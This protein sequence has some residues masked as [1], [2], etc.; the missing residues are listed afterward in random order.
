MTLHNTYVTT[1]DTTQHTSYYT[2]GTTIHNTTQHNTTQHTALHYTQQQHYYTRHCAYL[3]SHVPLSISIKVC[4]SG[5]WFVWGLSPIRTPCSPPWWSILP[6]MGGRRRVAFHARVVCSHPAGHDATSSE[7]RRREREAAAAGRPRP[8]RR[9][10]CG[11][12]NAGSYVWNPTCPF[13]M[14]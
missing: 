7:R 10:G 1:H 9:R 8:E 13:G 11:F 6:R 3:I 12:D 2:Y 4:G 14:V 5:G